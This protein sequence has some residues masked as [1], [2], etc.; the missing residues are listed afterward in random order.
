MF[1]RI[2]EVPV[3]SVAVGLL[4]ISSLIGLVDS[5]ESQFRSDDTFDFDLGAPLVG[6]F[7]LCWRA[8]FGVVL[9]FIAATSIAIVNR[10]PP[11]RQPQPASAIRT[12]T[13]RPGRRPRRPTSPRARAG[14]PRPATTP[15][16]TPP[17][18][19]QCTTTDYGNEV[20]GAW[21]LHRSSGLQLRWRSKCDCHL[22][23]KSGGLISCEWECS[24]GAATARDST[25]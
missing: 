9:A 18:A 1:H 23:D 11:P 13:G 20:G 21:H 14:A 15:A 25:R 3:P 5:F 10:S 7:S 24:P 12:R 4:C 17:P 8:P 22:K 19:R 6:Y 2:Y 16:A